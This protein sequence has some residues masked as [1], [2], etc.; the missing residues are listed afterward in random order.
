MSAALRFAGRVL[1]QVVVGV[2]LLAALLT[3]EAL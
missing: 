3:W 1:E 2:A